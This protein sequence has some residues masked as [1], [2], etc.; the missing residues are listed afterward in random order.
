MTYLNKTLKI[1]KQLLINLKNIVVKYENLVALKDINLTINKQDYIY[2]IGPN[3]AGKSTLIKLLTGLLKPTSGTIEI[4]ANHIGYLPQVLNQKPNF[5]I[6]VNEVIYTGF[7]K[8]RLIMTKEDKALIQFWLDRMDVSSI[9]N[10]LMS[11]LSGGQQQRVFLIRALISN[12][13]VLILDEPTSALDP[14]FRAHFYQLLEELHTKGTTIIFITHEIGGSLAK[15][16]II[17]LDQTIEFIGNY[18][19]YQAWGGHHHD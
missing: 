17:Y 16:K 11:T 12:P 6:T 8:Q 13:E 18:D 3:G 4:K 15:G 5:P 14:S 2:I 10:Q 7:K 19:N 9:G 1:S